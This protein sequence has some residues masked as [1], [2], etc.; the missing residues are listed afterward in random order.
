MSIDSAAQST[1]MPLILIVEEDPQVLAVMQLVLHDEGHD[2][3][4]A[5][6]YEDA[7]S[8]LRSER[9][10]DLVLTELEFAG[11]RDAGIRLAIEARKRWAEIPIIYTSGSGVSPSAAVLFVQQSTYLQKPYGPRQL[12][13]AVRALAAMR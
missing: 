13:D 10:I 12:A 4:C 3:V 7:L 8:V 9:K 11:D 2:V 1:A 6:A 5:G